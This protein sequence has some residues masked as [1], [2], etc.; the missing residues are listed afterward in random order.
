MT[1]KEASTLLLFG[2]KGNLARVKLFPGLF[3]LDLAGKLHPD[4]KIVLIGRQ[5]ESHEEWIINLKSIIRAKYDKDLNQTVLDRFL[6]RNVYH[7]NLPDDPDAFIKLSDRLGQEGFSQNL[8][9]FLSVRPS[10]F[11]LIV[12]QL[13][14]AKLLDESSHWKRV[15]IEKPFGVNTETA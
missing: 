12:D 6:K 10:D 15:L 5:E 11:A 1:Q 13:A 8:A 2:A 3:K 14:E 7:A 9:F 4:M